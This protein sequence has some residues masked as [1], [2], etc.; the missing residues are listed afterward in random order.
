MKYEVIDLKD[1][2]PVKGGTLKCIAMSFPWD[3]G[4]EN[5]KRPAVIVVPG[6]AYRMVS[7]REGEPVAMEFL[8]KG[9]QVFVLTYLCAPQGVSYPEQLIEVASAVDYVKTHAEEYSVNPDEVFVVG[10]SAGGHLTANLAVEHQNAS[11]KAGVELD[12]KPTAV[13]LCYPV[14]SRK[15]GHI[16]SHDNLL[17]QYSEEEKA[18]LLKTL[19]LDEQVSELTPPC[20]IWSTKEDT[21][22]PCENSLS[23][24]MELAKKNIPFE[25]HVYPNGG[26]GKGTGNLEINDQVT[27][28]EARISQWVE[29]CIAF[30]RSF[31]VEKF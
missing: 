9:F 3:A 13:G 27:P 14:I 7:S 6:G 26:H 12:C 31:C 25:L 8:A 21:A 5:W 2:Y 28:A 10:F 11:A 16:A 19:D 1:F 30:F 17:C 20:F 24:A 15:R 4:H 23:F 18:I 29:N 22:V